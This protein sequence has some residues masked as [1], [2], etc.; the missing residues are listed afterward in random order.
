MT[1]AVW[2][3]FMGRDEDELEILYDLHETHPVWRTGWFR[4]CAAALCFGIAWI[5]WPF[6]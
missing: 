1:Y 4:I 6:T 2:E 3:W 5:F